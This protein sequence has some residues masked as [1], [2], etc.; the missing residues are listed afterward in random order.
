MK[1]PP[2]ESDS[3]LLEC[4]PPERRTAQVPAHTAAGNPKNPAIIEMIIDASFIVVVVFPSVFFLGR[5]GTA[6]Q[7]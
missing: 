4:A 6:A 5:G 1:A 3:A 2:A 7:I